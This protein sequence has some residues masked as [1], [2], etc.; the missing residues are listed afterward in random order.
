MIAIG[1]DG[2]PSGLLIERAWSTAHARSMAAYHDPDRWTRMSIRNV[3]RI[4]KFS[5]DRAVREYCTDIWRVTPV[6]IPYGSSAQETD[7]EFRGELETGS[8]AGD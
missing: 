3:A 4:G 6:A 7:A 2:A 5:S 8:R 1:T